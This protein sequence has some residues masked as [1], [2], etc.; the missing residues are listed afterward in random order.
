MPGDPLWTFACDLY[1]RPSVA[2]ACL[3]L[4]DEA[5]ADV[6]VLLYLI[7][8][9]RTGRPVDAA[10]VVRAE[11]CI[12]SWRGEVIEPLRAVRRAMRSNLLPGQHIEACREGGTAAPPAPA[13]RPRAARAPPAPQPAGAAGPG[14][15][16]LTLY[17]AHLGAPWS[18]EAARALRA[19]LAAS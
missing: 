19:A 17:A 4:Q 15:A 11:A 13:R 16:V 8:C 7:W 5:G 1:G 9:A 3:L 18:A 10:E 14:D 12:T 6:P 2:Q